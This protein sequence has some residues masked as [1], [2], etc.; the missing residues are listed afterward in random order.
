MDEAELAAGVVVQ[1]EVEEVPAEVAEGDSRG[2]PNP[3]L[4]ERK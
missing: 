4:R 1:E 2:L 3:L